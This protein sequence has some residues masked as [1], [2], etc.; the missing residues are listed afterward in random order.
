MEVERLGAG[1]QQVVLHQ[2]LA[3]DELGVLAAGPDA[4]GGVAGGALHLVA[5]ADQQVVAVVHHLARAQLAVPAREDDLDVGEMGGVELPQGAGVAVDGQF[6]AVADHD[7]QVG[8]F[9]GGNARELAGH[10]QGGF[11]G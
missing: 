5:D 3:V 10:G 2:H 8:T 4:A 7:D 9:G 1:A 6:V 11:M